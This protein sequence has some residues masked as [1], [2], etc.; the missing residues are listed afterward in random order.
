MENKIGVKCSEAKAIQPILMEVQ[1]LDT[2]T[3]CS[4][5]KLFS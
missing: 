3:D 2:A 5:A 4:D 1:E